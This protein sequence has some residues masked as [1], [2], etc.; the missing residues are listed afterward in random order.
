M[1]EVRHDRVGVE[2]V[3]T[4]AGIAVLGVIFGGFV[5]G[6]LNSLLHGDLTGAFAPSGIQ[7]EAVSHLSTV[8][9]IASVLLVFARGTGGDLLLRTT[10][11]IYGVSFLE[12]VVRELLQSSF[13]VGFGLFVGPLYP[14]VTFFGYVVAFH[15]VFERDDIV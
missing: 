7:Y 15:I 2:S 5:V 3:A 4:A 11:A 14:V 1:A 9:V 12:S 13:E 6:V 8:A 10:A